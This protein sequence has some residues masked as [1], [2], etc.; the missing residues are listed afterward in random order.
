MRWWLWR[1]YFPPPSIAVMR[2]MRA[3]EIFTAAC[4][5]GFFCRVNGHDISLVVYPLQRRRQQWRDDGVIG[6]LPPRMCQRS[7]RL[8]PRDSLWIRLCERVVTARC[9]D[10]LFLSDF[11]VLC[12]SF[13]D[14]V[15]FSLSLHKGLRGFSFINF[16]M[17][18]GNYASQSLKRVW[19]Q[20]RVKIPIARARVRPVL[21]FNSRRNSVQETEHFRV[22][23]LF[24]FLS[25][26]MIRYFVSSWKSGV[27]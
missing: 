3:T 12:L 26:R 18:G 23:F 27:H 17:T 13:I 25:L 14:F 10:S 5:R 11:L 15:S 4:V 2:R 7:K 20:I 22:S 6:R 24:F 19:G 1:H 21:V 8:R 16:K 9:S